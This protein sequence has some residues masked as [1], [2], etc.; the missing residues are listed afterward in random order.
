MYEQVIGVRID[1]HRLQR[2]KELS[3]ELG[4][5]TSELIRIALDI[6]LYTA[7]INATENRIIIELNSEKLIYVK[8]KVK[9]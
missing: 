1:R 5:S 6:L 8:N 9:K 7:E 4:I 2:L 3:E